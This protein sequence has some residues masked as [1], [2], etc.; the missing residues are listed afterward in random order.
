MKFD[1]VIMN[2][3]YSKNLHLKILEQA[4]KQLK[5]DDSVAVNLSPIRWLEDPLVFFKTNTDYKKFKMTVANHILDLDVLNVNDAE[6]I[7]NIGL[8]F[9]LGVYILSKND[10]FFNLKNKLFSDSKFKVFF[11]IIEKI[12]D[13]GIQLNPHIELTVPYKV[14]LIFSLFTG[15]CNG[16]LTNYNGNVFGD[17]EFEHLCYV[18]NKNLKTGQTYYEY[19]KSICWGNNKPKDKN[20]ILVFDSLSTAKNFYK[21]VNTLCHRFISRISQVDINIHPK[22]LPWL[23]DIINPRTGLKGYESEWTNEDLYQYF[24][25][26]SEEQKVIE[27]AMKQYK[28]DVGPRS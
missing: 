9:N 24:D 10:S 1:C 3:P 17:H 26:T 28:R 25:I 21:S 19:R 27:D 6:K 8:P 2:P 7:F 15:G 12:I 18:D 14:S 11:K 23:G 4:V 22:Y 16:R 20:T 5:D 13:N